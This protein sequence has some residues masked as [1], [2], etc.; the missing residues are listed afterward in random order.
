M[1]TGAV[2][3]ALVHRRADSCQQQQH[4]QLPVGV[5]LGRVGGS[6][7]ASGE[8]L[9]VGRDRLDKIFAIAN[10]VL[11]NI[12]VSNNQRFFEQVRQSGSE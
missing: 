5:R 4:A 3:G 6:A 12:R 10:S 2:D 8:Q 9:R 11:E 1:L 7:A